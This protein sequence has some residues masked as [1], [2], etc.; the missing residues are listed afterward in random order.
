MGNLCCCENR[1]RDLKRKYKNKY[2]KYVLELDFSHLDKK[3]L[4]RIQKEEKKSERRKRLLLKK[5]RFEDP[6]LYID[7]EEGKYL[8]AN[9]NKLDSIQSRKVPD[10][11]TSMPGGGALKQRKKKSFWGPKNHD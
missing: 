1:H 9:E 2:K 5:A 3:R 11:R 10:K 8:E 4:S 6:S 7:D